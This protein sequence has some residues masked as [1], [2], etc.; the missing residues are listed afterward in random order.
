[1]SFTRAA[2]PWIGPALIAIG[3]AWF[4]NWI[5]CGGPYL[6]PPVIQACVLMG[7]G[8][9]LIRHVKIPER[10]AQEASSARAG[11]LTQAGPQHRPGD[12]P[13]RTR[14]LPDYSLR[15]SPDDR[16]QRQWPFTKPSWFGLV[17]GL[18]FTVVLL[19]NCVITAWA[20]W[21]PV[22]LTIR[23]VRPGLV[24]PSYAGIQPLRI[25]IGPGLGKLYVDAKPAH[26]EDLAPTLRQ[27]L[28][29]R[30]P[31]WPVYI[32]GDPDL[33]WKDVAPAVDTVR[34]LGAQ[35]VLITPSLR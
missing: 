1:M 22:G 17:A 5:F 16:P 11:C 30:P 26:W 24:A 35:V 12:T 13:I 23:L 4:A 29:R 28:S 7:I 27:A 9:G 34:G 19:V 31:N 20:Q 2:T 33:E 10:Q 8:W 15:R 3:I 14:A 18:T 6:P 25:Q 21:I 32:D